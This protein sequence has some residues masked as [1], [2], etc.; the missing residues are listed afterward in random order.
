MTLSCKRCKR[1]WNPRVA[2]PRVCPYCKSPYWNLDRGQ[3]RG[4]RR[5]KADPARVE[6]PEENPPC[7]YCGGENVT[8]GGWIPRKKGNIQRYICKDCRRT[9]VPN[10]DI[11]GQ[12]FVAITSRDISLEATGITKKMVEAI[13][14]NPQV[15]SVLE[16]LE[17]EEYEKR[18]KDLQDKTESLIQE[19]D[20]LQERID[21]IRKALGIPEEDAGEWN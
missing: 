3:P 17:R 5:Y 13:R 16:S 14:K 12:V 8:K 19:R 4:P 11:S 18:I 15:F 2:S 7:V 21:T 10:E 9:F 1:S 6:P 20:G